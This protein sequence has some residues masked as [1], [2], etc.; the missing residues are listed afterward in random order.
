MDST[1][2]QCEH[3]IAWSDAC[4]QCG[5]NAYPTKD[6]VFKLYYGYPCDFCEHRTDDCGPTD[7]FL[8]GARIYACNL[9]DDGQILF[10]NKHVLKMI[11]NVLG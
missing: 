8:N 10:I 7:K 9:L 3:G 5:R 1:T 11:K 6:G 2:A 4:P